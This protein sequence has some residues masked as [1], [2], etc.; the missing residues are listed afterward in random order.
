MRRATARRAQVIT[1]QAVGY[2]KR[3]SLHNSSSYPA[4]Y[5][6]GGGY[7]Y[8]PNTANG[9]V[10]NGNNLWWVVRHMQPHLLHVSFRDMLMRDRTVLIAIPC[11]WGVKCPVGADVFTGPSNIVCTL[12]ASNPYICL[13]C[14]G[15]GLTAALVHI[16]P[17]CSDLRYLSWYLLLP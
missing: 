6:S 5:T 4:T 1:A 15:L 7:Y 11:L 14:R 13:Y 8:C 9:E 17:A 10:L 16:R 3:Y 12:H 2:I